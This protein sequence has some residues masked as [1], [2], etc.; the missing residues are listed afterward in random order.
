MIYL[1]NAAT[2]Q[3]LPEVL[4]SMMPYFTEQ[5][6][7]PSAIYSLGSSGKR[8]IN[9]ARSILAEGIGAKREE[10]YFT[11]GG[12]EAD[13]WA[14][15]MVA[16]N[17]GDEGKHIITTRIE[18]HAVL[19]TCEYLEKKGYQVSYLD[20]DG[21][22]MVSPQAVKDAIRPDTILISIMFANNEVGTIEPIAE[23]GRIAREA[24]VLFHTDAVQAFGQLPIQVDDMCIDLLSA[25]AHKIH[26]PKGVG[27]L[28]VRTGVKISSFLHGGAQERS[29]RAGT[30]NVPGIVGFGTAAK[31]A[32]EQMQESSG[33]KRTLRDYLIEQLEKEIVGCKLNGHR[34]KRLPGNVNMS[35]SG[36]EGETV[37][38]RLDMQGICASTGSA[39]TSGSLEPS[40][41]LLAMGLDTSTA[42]SSIRFSLSE[43]NTYDEADVLV[44]C[45]KEIVVS[46]RETLDLG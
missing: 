13:N 6:G 21:D 12:S 7:N 27:M 40:H 15:K 22:G 3:I 25:S 33:Y 28:Y 19:H 29:R 14:I 35:L 26:G 36:M 45:L 18:H 8:A 42:K 37:L 41:V 32:L 24:G 17:Y 23:I 46:L 10:I 9:E 31:L 11:G 5:Y 43:E 44:T 30:E 1:D 38:I 39:C 16:E 34:T 2:T 20:V 4:E